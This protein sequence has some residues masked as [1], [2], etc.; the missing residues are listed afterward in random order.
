MW[1]IDVKVDQNMIY[2]DEGPHIFMRML[3]IILN[4]FN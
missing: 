1:W 3:S 4:G 2:I